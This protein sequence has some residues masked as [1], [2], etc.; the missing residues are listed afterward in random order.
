MTERAQAPDKVIRIKAASKG[1]GL[2]T[3]LFWL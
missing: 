1:N 2:T 3:L